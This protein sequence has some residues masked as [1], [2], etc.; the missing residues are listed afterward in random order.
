MA[1]E[2]SEPL[3]EPNRESMAD[4]IRR[5][6]EPSPPLPYETD[7]VRFP[8]STRAVSLS[9]TLSRPARPPIGAVVLLSGS[10]PQDRDESIAGHR[11]FLVLADHL[12]RAGF[13]VLRWDDR[14]VNGSEGDYLDSSAGELVGDAIQAVDW[15]A[16][17]F[18]SAPLALVG[19]SQGAIV[20][21]RVVRRRPETVSALVLL[22]GGGRPGRQVLLDQHRNIARAEGVDEESIAISLEVK[23]LVFDLLAEA[24]ERLRATADRETILAELRSRLV[25]LFTRG[26]GDED[27]G[28]ADRRELDE[29]VD[30]LLEWEWRFLVTA[31]PAGDLAEVQAPVLALAG[32]RDCQ[33]SPAEELAGIEAALRES[34][35]EQVETEL[36]TGLN[37]L[38]QRCST[39]GPSEYSKIEQTWSEMAL[40][41]VSD[42]LK[43]ALAPREGEP[44]SSR[45]DAG[46]RPGEPSAPSV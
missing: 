29:V 2:S 31:D 44:A 9:G 42:W 8:G 34:G 1:D 7:E 14:G 24:G 25:D 40:R 27:L 38:F 11:P 23:A 39:G 19:H 35:N 10:G 15:L 33:I 37:H 28:E 3:L 20:A 17:R 6:Q 26:K 4:G 12:T 32:D 18:P 5:P 36:F 21:A 46:H 43:G 22:A 16:E 41:R 45:T 30:D 13:A